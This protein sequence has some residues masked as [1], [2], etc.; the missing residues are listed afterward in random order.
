MKIRPVGAEVLRAKET[1]GQTEKMKL[2]VALRNFAEA[3][4]KSKGCIM[5]KECYL[6]V[7]EYS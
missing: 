3:P 2:I 5:L 7:S 4:K 1:D 6:C